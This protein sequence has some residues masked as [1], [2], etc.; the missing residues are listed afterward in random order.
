M[1]IQFNADEVFRIGMEVELN[2]KAFYHEAS[3]LV[4]SLEL[5]VI[6]ELLR[7]EEEKHYNAFAAMREKLP[8][9]AAEETVYDPEGEMGAYLKALADS[10]VFT[11]ESQASEVARACDDEEEILRLALK[12]EKDSVLV[13]QAMRD[14]TKAEWGKE[15][16][17]W[18]IEQERDHVRKISGAL[19]AL[20]RLG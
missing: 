13:F 6:L 17:D 1:G 5:R 4:K 18:L 8:A 16:I 3:T 14:L 20:E 11:S 19:A 15:K 2:G 10:R 9:A 7:D 12:F